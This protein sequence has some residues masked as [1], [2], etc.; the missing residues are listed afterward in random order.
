[1]LNLERFHLFFDYFLGL[2]SYG[3]LWDIW[4]IVYRDFFYESQRISLR[5]LQGFH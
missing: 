1:M 2:S 5:N 3:S 4:G